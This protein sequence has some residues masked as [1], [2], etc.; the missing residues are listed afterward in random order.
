[1]RREISGDHLKVDKSVLK[2][3][4]IYGEIFNIFLEAS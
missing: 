4:W 3:R 1:M 2:A